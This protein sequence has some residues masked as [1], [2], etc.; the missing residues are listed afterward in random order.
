MIK[1]QHKKLLGFLL[2]KGALREKQVEEVKNILKSS[3]EKSLRDILIKGGFVDA[4]KL[5]QFEA[6]FF[7]YPY[8]NLMQRKVN[9]DIQEIMPLNL[10]EQH[11]AICFDQQGQ[12]LKIAIA[13]P[14]DYDARE[15]I[16]FW[17]SSKGFSVEYYLCSIYAWQEALKRYGAFGDDV[18]TALGEVEK[19]QEEKK[20]E[21]DISTDNIEE[22]I[23]SAPVAQIVSMII[24]HGVESRA[25]DIHIE[26]FEKSSRV[27]FRIDGILNT[28]L[29]LPSYIHDSVISR[30]KVLSNL[31]IDETRVPQDGRS[32]IHIGKQD[33][34]LR[35]SVMPLAGK[36][37]ITIRILDTG[38]KALTLEQLGFSKE[39]R[40][41]IATALK[42]TYGM[43]L[44]TGPTGSGKSTTL[45]SILS[46]MNKEGINISTLEDPVEY[47][48]PGINQAQVRPEVKFTFAAG[49]RALMR[50][51][52]DIIMVGEIRDHETGE[53]GV[54]AAL[55]G[56]LLFST[57]H[58]ND[59]IGAVPRLMDMKVEPFLLASTLNLIIAQRL[60][61]RICSKCKESYDLPNDVAEKV[62][63]E[64]QKVDPKK[65]PKEI[66]LT[67]QLKAYRGKGCAIC[68]NTGY[69]G[70]IVISEVLPITEKMRIII[71]NGFKKPEVLEEL[72]RIGMISLLQDGI[73]KSLQGFTSLEEIFRVSKEVEEQE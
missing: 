29:T 60:G 49:L 13:K 27:R 8:E 23:K 63:R 5:A 10:A 71:S 64:L 12:K 68:K 37:K 16:D 4:E 73:I 20:L 18:A 65:L 3:E 66:D 43:I 51:D 25:S 41:V 22:V 69:S 55:T 34:D 24:K 54:H 1:E 21:E 57:L 46:S 6:E 32:K 31:K 40:D 56:H 44:V 72:K 2:Q 59:S 58:T 28:V 50:Q 70:R 39:L 38:S 45:F 42:Q 48:I 62:K 35:I 7:N 67:G 53:M 30:I 36:E 11:S 17:A 19:D 61:R 9:P 52:P 14:E 33:Y 15:A 26:P 47:N